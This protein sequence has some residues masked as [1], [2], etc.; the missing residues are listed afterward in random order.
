LIHI[1]TFD[2]KITPVKFTKVVNAAGPFAGEVARMAGIGSAFD[3]TDDPLRS[4]KVGLPVEP[5]KRYIY[6]F[7]ADNGPLINVPLTIDSSGVF[8]RRHDLSNVYLCGLNQDEARF[9]LASALLV[10]D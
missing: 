4:L 10:F 9:M 3:E 2:N 6:L 8:F 1:D 5:R 7:K